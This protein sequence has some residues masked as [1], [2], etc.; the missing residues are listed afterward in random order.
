MAG[1]AVSDDVVN[2]SA[3]AV[4][5]VLVEKVRAKIAE[6]VAFNLTGDAVDSM[7][8]LLDGNK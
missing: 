4:E 7:D 3:I 2:R 6:R 8:G 5:A 1:V